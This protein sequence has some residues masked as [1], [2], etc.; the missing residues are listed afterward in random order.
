M[1]WLGLTDLQKSLFNPN[2]LGT[3]AAN[4][5][6]R[7]AEGPNHHILTHGTLMLETRF[8]AEGDEAQE[9]LTYD[10][11]KEWHRHLSIVLFGR[12]LLE[13][14]FQ[15][16]AAELTARLCFPV[17]PKD[18]R[19]RISYAWNAPERRA[20]LA[21]EM[22]TS[23]ETYFET[24]DDPLPMPEV[25]ALTIMRNGRATLIAKD[26]DFVAISDEIEP[27]GLALG[28]LSG[29]MIDT[30]SGP[31]PIDRL[32]LGDM[33]TTA[34]RGA[35]SVRWITQRTVPALGAFAP[36]KLRAPFFGLSRDVTVAPNH[37]LSVGGAEAEYLVGHDDV[38]IEARQLVSG[39]GA[40][41]GHFRGLVTYY[42]LLLDAH[43]CVMSDGLWSETLYV[44]QLAR[45]EARHMASALSEM[46]RSA[47]PRHTPISQHRLADFEASSIAASLVS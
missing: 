21:V 24:V 40:A 31:V 27:V 4:A 10:R 34:A 33:V 43:D 23:G 8:H 15:Q 5:P 29:T 42:H 47:L 35:Q 22:T 30:P 45:D 2:G 26:V 25:D 37:M 7:K 19:L 13:V 3:S 1:S 16:G 17:P 9:V 18:S 6:D 20:R 12:G 14:R 36:V 28:F 32:R 38:M 46:P 39:P 11:H 44:G 41:R